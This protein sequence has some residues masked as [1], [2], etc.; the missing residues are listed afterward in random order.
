MDYQKKIFAEWRLRTGAFLSSP[1][2]AK[3][4]PANLDEDQYRSYLLE[5]FFHTRQNPFSQVI[6]AGHF[7]RDKHDLFR[8]FV[9]HA[10][11][12]VKH[13]LLAADDFIAMGGDPKLLNGEPLQATK[14]IIDY[15][16]KI[17]H[18]ANPIPYLAYL[19]HVEHLPTQ[20]GQA[21]VDQLVSRGVEERAISFL[22]EH[23]QVDVVHNK[24]MAEYIEELVQNEDDYKLFVNS[25]GPAMEHH[26]AMI[27]S[28]LSRKI[29]QTVEIKVS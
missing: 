17:A 1:A 9:M 7:P 14:Q 22:A 10:L 13:D 21:Y 8:K 2:A 28:A 11:G 25:F 27:I 16:F 23:V 29:K 15:T 24:M 4:N 5:T 3:M 19:Y 26:F 12:E 20:N 6:C 18:E